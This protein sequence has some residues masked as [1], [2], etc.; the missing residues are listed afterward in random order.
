MDIK[1]TISRHD[2]WKKHSFETGRPSFSDIDY[3]RDGTTFYVV[4]DAE[5][6]QRVVD[7]R[8]RDEE[9]KEL[10]KIRDE[11]IDVSQY[12]DLAHLGGR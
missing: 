6:V 12:A 2:D 10:N 5:T 7:A 8:Q 3:E 9:S 11:I 1:V 4:F